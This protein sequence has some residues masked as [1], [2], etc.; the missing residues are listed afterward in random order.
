VTTEVISDG[1]EAEGCRSERSDESGSAPD[2]IVQPRQ[3]TVCGYGFQPVMLTLWPM[4]AMCICARLISQQ[5]P[6]TPWLHLDGAIAER[7]TL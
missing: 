6:D 7:M 5:S 1:G 2:H 4:T 3:G